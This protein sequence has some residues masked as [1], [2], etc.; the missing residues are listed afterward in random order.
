MIHCRFWQTAAWEKA[1]AMRDN[2]IDEHDP[3]WPHSH[4]WDMVDEI[5]MARHWDGS[6]IDQLV[7]YSNR[8]VKGAKG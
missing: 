6:V 1:R 5:H 2:L 7:D 8:P 3:E 4:F